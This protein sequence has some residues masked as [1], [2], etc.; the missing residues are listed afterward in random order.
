MKKTLLL[1]IAS[2]LLID[3]INAQYFSNDTFGQSQHYS[4]FPRQDYIYVIGDYQDSSRS[5]LIPFWTKFDYNGNRIGFD[6]L[7]DPLY[8]Y[9]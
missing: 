1:F 7:W 3:F 6:T 2:I 4:V 8:D 9:R 5:N